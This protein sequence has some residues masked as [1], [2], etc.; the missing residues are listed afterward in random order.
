MHLQDVLG[1]VSPGTVRRMHRSPCT[2]AAELARAAHGPAAAAADTGT[3]SP[4]LT[5]E[6]DFAEHIQLPA[7]PEADNSPVLVLSVYSQTAEKTEPK[8]NKEK[9]K[10]E[11]Q[12]GH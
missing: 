1:S 2:S 4:F 12:A 3:A 6:S 10:K 11:N 8:Q 5:P 9:K 7:L